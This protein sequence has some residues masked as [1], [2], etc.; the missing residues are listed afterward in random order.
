MKIY[1]YNI[2]KEIFEDVEIR[3]EDVKEYGIECISTYTKKG[4]F[5]SFIKRCYVRL[6]DGTL[7][8]NIPKHQI[9]YLKAELKG[10]KSNKNTVSVFKKTRYGYSERKGTDWTYRRNDNG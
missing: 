3:K 5:K 1:H 6:V 2:Q 10:F 7:I 8:L 4:N 9:K